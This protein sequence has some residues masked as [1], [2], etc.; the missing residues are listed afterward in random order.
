MST[1]ASSYFC[2]SKLYS[3][4]RRV[5]CDIGHAVFVFLCFNLPC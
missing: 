5:L 1:F 3:Y 2:T 4:L